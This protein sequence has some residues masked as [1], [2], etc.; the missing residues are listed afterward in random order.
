MFTS[1]NHFQ[2][3][4]FTGVPVLIVAVD[5]NGN[6]IT[7]D[8][9]TTNTDGLFHYTWTTPDGYRWMAESAF[10]CIKCVF[11]EDI[12]FGKVAKHS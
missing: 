4:N 6:Y 8:N 1:K 10:S 2:P 9:A 7:I 12:L 3:T 11:G 5:P